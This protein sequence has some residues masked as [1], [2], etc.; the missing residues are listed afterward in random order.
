[1]NIIQH[2][3]IYNFIF[4]LEGLG[5]PLACRGRMLD[6]SAREQ[7]SVHVQMRNDSHNEGAEIVV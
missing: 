1:M 5:K 2:Y 3:V 6:V 4:I 7:G